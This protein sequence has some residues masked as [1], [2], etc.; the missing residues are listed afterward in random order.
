MEGF[1]PPLQGVRAGNS[2]VGCASPGS[3][4]RVGFSVRE[5]DPIR[6]ISVPGFC[7]Q[8]TLAMDLVQYMHEFSGISLHQQPRPG[9]AA[10]F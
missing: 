4:G 10:K 7:F 9:Q 6:H 3:A 5:G 8:W 1:Y 2:L